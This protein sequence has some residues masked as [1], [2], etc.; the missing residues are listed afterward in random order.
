MPSARSPASS[1]DSGSPVAPGE[2]LAGKY[3]V[4]SVLGA[5]GMGL[6]VAATHLTLHQRVALKFLRA[7]AARMPET[8]ERFLREAQAAVRLKSEHVAKVLDV[9]TL[10]DGSPYMVMEYLEGATLGDV[11]RRHGPLPVAEAVSHVVQACEAVA[12]AHAAGIVHR[13]IKPDNL[14]LTKS[15]H[16]RHLV[17]V[18]DFGIAKTIGVD[19]HL[20][21]TRTSTIVGSPL[22]MPPEQLRSAKHV[23]VRADIWALGAVLF[24]LV[25]GRP[26]FVAESFSELCLKVATDPTPT[27][28]SVNPDVP[29]ALDAVVLRCLE[30]DPAKRFQNVGELADALQAFASESV[31]DF[32]RLVSSVLK[33]DSQPAPPPPPEADTARPSGGSLSKA[34]TGTAWGHTSAGTLGRRRKLVWL[35]GGAAAVVAAAAIAAVAMHHVAPEASVSPA[36]SG[37]AGA[38]TPAASPTPEPP[39]VSLEAPPAVQPSATPSVSASSAAPPSSSALTPVRRVTPVPSPVVR[40]SGASPSSP[41]PPS[42]PATATSAGDIVFQ[43]K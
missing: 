26:P 13:D 39:A 42:A 30:K 43:R 34:S 29:P 3:R 40:A 7:D 25:A 37:V 24:E 14:F 22:Y 31:R 32:A 2:V 6:V 23:D 17:K 12:E 16:G 8:K 20:S 35:G 36:A 11:V 9:G 38:T 1:A 41:P 19:V 15:V 4:D 27:P 18:L 33:L 21:L 5:G 28:S 10:E